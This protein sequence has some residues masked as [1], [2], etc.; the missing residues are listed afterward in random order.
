MQVVDI[1]FIVFNLLYYFLF[2]VLFEQFNV[3]MWVI[4]MSFFVYSECSGLE[5]NVILLDVL[6]CQCCNLVLLCFWG[7]LCDL[8]CFYCE[9]LVLLQSDGDGLL[10]GE[11]LQDGGY[12]CVFVDEY[13]LLMVLV[14]WLVFMVVLVVFLVCYL[15]QFMVN[16]QM[17]QVSGCVL[18][19]VV[20]GGLVC[21]IDVMWCCWQVWECLECWVYGVECYVQGVC[22]YS[23]VGLEGFD[24][25]V[26]V[27]YSDQVLVM[28]FDVD[29]IECVVFGVI[30]YQFNEVVLY[31]DVWLLFMYCKVWVVWNVYV[32]VLLM[33]LCMVSYCMNLLQGIDMFMLLV[34]MFNC[35]EVIDLVKVLCCLQYLYFVYDYVM[36][37]VQGCWVEVQ[38]WCWIWFVGVYWGWGFYEDGICSVCCVVDVLDV[39]DVDVYWLL[40]EVVLV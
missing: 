28:L 18:W 2:I 21:Y 13:L 31:I 40:F 14:F 20:E 3:V 15:V 25:L 16:Y 19:Q 7:M 8:W 1:G 30:C 6:F 17:L 9:V 10:F 4:I 37:C 38:G 33:V 27:C 12:G 24:Q 39:L 29:L 34:V 23:V 36:V 32:L 11:Y 5:Y 22:V 26:L 35:S